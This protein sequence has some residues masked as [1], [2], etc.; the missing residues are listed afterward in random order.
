MIIDVAK[1]TRIEDEV[2]RRGIK[3]VGRGERVG[4]CPVCGGRDQFSIN[5]KKQVWNCRGCA[6]GGDVVD[7]VQ[8]LD[9]VDFKAAIATLGGDERKPI[10]PA[11]KATA[12]QDDDAANTARA[13]KLWEEG[14]PIDGTLAEE[15]L[16]RRGLEPPEGDDALRFYNPCPFGAGK[17]PCL[18][19]LFRDIVTNEPKA[20]HRIALGPEGILIGK[21]IWRFNGACLPSEALCEGLSCC[22]SVRS[23]RSARPRLRHNILGR[24]ATA[25]SKDAQSFTDRRPI[26]GTRAW[27]SREQNMTAATQ[28]AMPVTHR[29]R[30]SSAPIG[31]DRAHR[32]GARGAVITEP[33]CVSHKRSRIVGVTSERDVG[34][35]H[36]RNPSVQRVFMEVDLKVDQDE[37]E[38]TDERTTATCVRRDTRRYD[39]DLFGS[40]LRGLAPI[41]R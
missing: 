19:A 37:W 15:Y 33:A 40:D 28:R 31:S 32:C 41:L 7:M 20:I 5:V 39:F 26:A 22:S 27:I 23:L 4:P 9:G 16:R 1:V 6:R 14:S 3:L 25:G 11:P 12:P 35:R 36:I 13:L 18:L 21:R 17:Y 8:H 29:N 10:R 34:R 24:V 2:T 38:S 30:P